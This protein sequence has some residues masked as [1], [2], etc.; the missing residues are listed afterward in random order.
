MKILINGFK[1]I[2]ESLDKCSDFKTTFLFPKSSRFDF[3]TNYLLF[4]RFIKSGKYKEFDVIYVNN[5]ENI[6]NIPPKDKRNDQVWITESHGIH[7]GLDY[8]IGA[9]QSTGIKKIF[10]YLFGSFIHSLIARQMEKF[11]INYVAIPNA[12]PY[13]KKI[14]KDSMWLPNPVDTTEF[15]SSG[16]KK[17]LEGS[18]AVVYPTRLHSVKNP[19]F[20]FH[21]FKEIKAKYPCAK[22]HLIRYPKRFT[23]DSVYKN[24][25]HELRKDIV[26]H[27]FMRR[28]NLPAF[29]RGA[30][31]ILGS[32]SQNHYYA[33]LNLV[34][35]EAMACGAAVVACDKYEFIKR[36]LH[37]L[38]DFALRLL[39]DKKFREKYIRDSIAYV[40]KV[41]SIENLYTTV[42]RDI[43]ATIR[44]K[45]T[46]L[47]NDAYPD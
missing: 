37:G 14:R 45:N 30:D 11:D 10:A 44:R 38:P 47:K 15:S 24:E 12:L 35:L 17:D 22:L 34:E 29:Y 8:K 39:E 25:L 28:E 46:Q 13:A 32:F 42:K 20:A 7:I 21:L 2:K 3:I 6:L 23:E 26:W 36:E 9:S 43:E 18:P 1:F 31:L 19:K 41:H 4:R 5:W 16:G 40:K 33:N 27:D